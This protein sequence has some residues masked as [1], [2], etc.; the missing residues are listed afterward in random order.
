MKFT[1]KFIQALFAFSLINMIFS[2][3]TLD[4]TNIE[5]REDLSQTQLWEALFTQKRN[6]DCGPTAAELALASLAL[7]DSSNGGVTWNGPRKKMNEWDKQNGFGPSAYLFDYL[8]EVLQAT[9]TAEF[10]KL[11]DLA[12]KIPILQVN[13][14]PVPDP[15]SLEKMVNMLAQTNDQGLVAPVTDN[16]N[17]P[18]LLEKMNKIVSGKKTVFNQDA[19]KAGITVPMVHSFV[20]AWKWSYNPAETEWARKLLDKYDFD[21]DGRLSPRE[22]I[23]FSIIHNKNNFAG[24]C[25]NCYNDIIKQ[26]IDPI[27]TFLDCDND[28]KVS[29]E[30]MWD[31]LKLL[32]RPSNKAD[33]Y[34]CSLNNKK[35]RTTSMNDFVLKNMWDN[36]GF[37]SKNEFRVGILLGYWDRQTSP[38]KIITNDDRT[39]KNLRWDSSNADIVCN[40]V[41]AIQGP[42]A[43]TGCCSKSLR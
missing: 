32:K 21:G 12:I 38:E 39:F 18:G 43:T 24:T 37:V 40:R 27:Y 29:A 3:K 30:D 16:A 1:K 6:S 41:L 22:F 36:D 17:D 25:E 35:Y 15:Y 9:I 28:N 5:R 13:G 2:S 14:A 11:Y 31:N 33:I 23:I 26:K 34:V 8:D 10:T 4:K 42:Q 7:T 19:F 20:I